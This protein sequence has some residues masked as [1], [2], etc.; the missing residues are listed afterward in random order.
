MSVQ[1]LEKEKNSLYTVN[2]NELYLDPDNNWVAR[3][4]LT[5]F[6]QQAFDLYRQARGLS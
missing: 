1:I 4:E 6:E 2:G 5:S 3:K